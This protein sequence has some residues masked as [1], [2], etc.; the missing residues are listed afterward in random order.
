MDGND[1]LGDCGYA[2]C[3][4]VDGIRSFGN[5]QPGF[6]QIV[7]DVAKLEAQYEAA[8]GGDNGSDEPMLVG[9]SG[10][11]MTGIAGDPAAV[12]VDHLDI[13]YTDVAL[14]NY[15]IDW[16]FATCLAWSVPDDVL[17]KFTTGVQFLSTDTPDPENGHYTPL[18]SIDA[19]SNYYLWTWGSYCVVSATF[20]QSVDPSGFVTFSA[21][22]FNKVTGCDAHGRH[23]SDVAAA[24]VALGGNASL[25]NP[26]VAQFPPK[27][28]PSAT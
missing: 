18:A 10:S 16:F 23:V 20:I 13:D 4:H 8:S 6:T 7:A 5:G 1:A 9:T 28:V 2:M 15:C 25:I 3:D 26:V 12:V 27:L 11:W 24:W 19:N 14:V 17:Q 21:L 22:Q